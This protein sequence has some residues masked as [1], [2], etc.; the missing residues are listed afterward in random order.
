MQFKTT[1]TGLRVG[2]GLTLTS[3]IRNI[4]KTF[5]I[6][7][8]VGKTRGNSEMIYT[9]YGIASGQIN[10]TDIMVN[11]LGQDK[12]NITIATNEVLQRLDVLAET[13]TFADVVTTTGKSRPYFWGMGT[14]NDLKW[15]FSTWY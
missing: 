12:K 15:G 9:I 2:Q 5:K 14:A 7:R 13:V 11:L 1:Q 6:N 3:T 4:N 8:I 10:F